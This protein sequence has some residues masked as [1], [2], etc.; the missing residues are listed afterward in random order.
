MN[1]FHKNNKLSKITN[2]KFILGLILLIILGYLGNLFKINLFFGV[3]FIFGS[4][5]SLIVVYFYG[6]KWGTLAALIASI[7][8]YFLWNHYYAIIIFTL[9]AMFVGVILNRQRFQNIVLLDGIYW[10][11]LGI[12]LVGL[13]YGFVL[14]LN[15]IQ[16]VLIML[17][18]SVNGFFNALI[19]NL[20]ITYVPINKLVSSSRKENYSSFQTTIFNFLMA[21]ILLPGLIIT[22]FDTQGILIHIE[23]DIKKQLILVKTPINN[24]L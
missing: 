20:I 17:N 6:T 9:E 16:T 3:D 14:H 19:C 1:F 4:I 7:H 8:T 18:Q 2:P 23:H 10:I 22:I 21:F 13:F 11:F 5:S 12:P 24:K 15:T